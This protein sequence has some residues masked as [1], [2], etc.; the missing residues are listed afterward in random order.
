MRTIEELIK[1]KPK[2]TKPLYSANLAY[3]SMF[4]NKSSN[5]FNQF[6]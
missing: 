4:K 6:K 2:K 1:N 5:N 3:P